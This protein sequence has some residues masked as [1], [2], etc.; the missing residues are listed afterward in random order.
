MEKINYPISLLLFFLFIISSLIYPQQMHKEPYL[1]YNG[2]QTEMQVVWQ[3]YSTDT[4]RIEWG[5]DTLFA[6]GNEQTYE[7]GSSHQHSYTITNL[8]PAEKYYYRVSV[9]QEFYSGIFHSAPDSNA[10]AVSF[11]VYGD[12]RSNPGIHNQVASA[13]IAA[14]N[15]D[16]DFQSIIIS[17]GDLVSNGESESIW[18]SEFFSPIYSSIREMLATLPYE[19][20]IG[21]HEGNGVLFTKY[22]PYP[23]VNGRYWSFDYGPAHFVVVDQYTSYGPGSAQLTWIENDL[24]AT[25]KRWKFI[26]L[27]EPG[28]S[29]GG[30]SNNTNV[31]NYIQPLCVE[32]G[33]PIVFGGHNHY[34][35]R[36]VAG[37]IQHI[38]TGGGGAPLYQPDP[39]YPN[40]VSTA[41]KNHYCKVKIIHDT[42][43]FTALTPSGEV[44]DSFTIVNPSVG[45]IPEWDR[46][47][48]PRYIL[49]DAYPNPFN[50]TTTISWQSPVSSWQSLKVYDMLGKEIATLVNA[51]KPA[52]SYN[53]EFTMHNTQLSSGVYIYQLR[54][55]SFVDTKKMIL[56]R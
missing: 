43:N 6:L 37:N 28:W 21:N 18:D 25:T 36:A 17:V 49:N 22:F 40:I 48:S 31:Q 29:A 51:Y 15:D 14:Y 52:G 53:V 50:P 42:L 2:N 30:H 45:V 27:H 38:T 10:D 16:P 54:A 33:V 56:L 26:Y 3:L 41:M 46:G 9:S 19:S 1:I 13:M 12:T 35:A 4:C 20:C 47:S 7:Y 11:F 55:G 5:T 32:Y 34:Y 24:A 23:F 39:N 44:I 8:T